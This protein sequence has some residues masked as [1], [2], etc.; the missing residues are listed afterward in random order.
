[1]GITQKQLDNMDVQQ[2]NMFF[3]EDGAPQKAG[4]YVCYINFP[5]SGVYKIGL[6]D[7]IEC[8]SLDNVNGKAVWSESLQY[9][10]DGVGIPGETIISHVS[11]D[12]SNL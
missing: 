10:A 4:R 9:E 8:R 3:W 2:L 5:L 7:A 12:V 1:M 6:V 11:E